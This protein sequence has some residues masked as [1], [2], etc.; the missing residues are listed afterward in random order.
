ML[1]PLSKLF[2]SIIF[3]AIKKN[4][5]NFFSTLFTSSSFLIDDCPRDE[6]IR[7]LSVFVFSEV[8]VANLSMAPRIALLS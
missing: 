8:T 4:G 7:I 6:E 2:F 3:F 1:I 5:L